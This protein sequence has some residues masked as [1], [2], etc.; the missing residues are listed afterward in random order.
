MASRPA[1]LRRPWRPVRAAV[2][3]GALGL[4]LALVLH[5][6]ARWVLE[7]ALS[8]LGPLR[9][10]QVQGS[11]WNGRA[12][13]GLGVDGAPLS[14]LPGGLMWRLRPRWVDG[15]P[16]LAL[17]LQA[18]CCM[19]EPLQAR[20]GLG[21]DGAGLRLE[22][23]RSE[24]P[25]HLLAGLGTPWN[26]LRLEGRLALALAPAQGLHRDGGWQVAGGLTLEMHDLSSRLSLQR[27]LG[28]Y[29]FELAWDP[30][31]S[32][33]PL[34]LSTLNGALQLQGE[35]RLQGGRLRFEGEAWAAPGHEAALDNLLNLLGRRQGPRAILRIG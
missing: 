7:P 23:H 30:T 26:T 22:A 5:F 17:S 13:V 21:R 19:A 24:W 29:R 27:P 8:G 1:P 33:A 12:E 32:A 31:A 9:L 14:G 11:V 18:P 25:A 34:R 35:G 16:W 15:G 20:V 28:S 4:L 2:W 10:M 6:P 3:G